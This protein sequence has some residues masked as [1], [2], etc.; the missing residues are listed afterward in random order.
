MCY[1]YRV[2]G[3]DSIAHQERETAMHYPHR[4]SEKGATMVEYGLMVALIA[5]VC[6]VGVSAVGA[7]INA[8]FGKVLA[9]GNPGL[10]AY[11]AFMLPETGPGYTFT[12][13]A[14]IP[15]DDS[16]MAAHDLAPGTYTC[17]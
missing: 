11:C 14:G 6:V 16:V 15:Y 10:T 1:N 5:V 4:R 9:G 8:I 13:I 12:L 3:T 7:K 2:G 17:P